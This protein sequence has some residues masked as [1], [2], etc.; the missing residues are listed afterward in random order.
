MLGSWDGWAGLLFPSIW[1]VSVGVCVCVC[2]YVLGNGVR[3]IISLTVRKCVLCVLCVC[4]FVF[5][6]VKLG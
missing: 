4:E 5:G 3:A 6:H 1:L 2:V